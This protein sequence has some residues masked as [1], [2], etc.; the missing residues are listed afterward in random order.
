M[1]DTWLTPFLM[2]LMLIAGG[3]SGHRDPGQSSITVKLPPLRQRTAE[4]AFTFRT[5]AHD[6]H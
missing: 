2:S 3:C 6:S 4:P 5:P 1:A